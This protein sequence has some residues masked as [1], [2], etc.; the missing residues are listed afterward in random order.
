V[1]DAAIPSPPP[2]LQPVAEGFYEAGLVATVL[3]GCTACGKS[4]PRARGLPSDTCECGE[5]LP[6]TIYVD[7]NETVITGG[8]IQLT[9]GKWLLGAAKGLNNLIRR[10]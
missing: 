3:R 5:D 7:A 4:H 8:D 2:I 6:E 10:L 1:T 9:I